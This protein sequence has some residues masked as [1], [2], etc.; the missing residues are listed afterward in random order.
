MF[1]EKKRLERLN[2]LYKKRIDEIWSKLQLKA[3]RELQ[4]YKNPV[5]QELA[6]LEIQ[7]YKHPVNIRG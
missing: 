6:R 1:K 7:N 4:N 5:L 2:V 3:A